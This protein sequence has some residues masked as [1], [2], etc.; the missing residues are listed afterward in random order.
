MKFYLSIICILF[1][2]RLDSQEPPAPIGKFPENWV[3]IEIGINKM[4]EEDLGPLRDARKNVL[5]EMEG[6]FTGD[7]LV[8][9]KDSSDQV[10]VKLIS[11]KGLSVITRVI[12]KPLPEKILSVFQKFETSAVSEFRSSGIKWNPQFRTQVAYRAHTAING[13]KYITYGKVADKHSPKA[14]EKA[15]SFLLKLKLSSVPKED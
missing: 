14:F 11:K 3:M 7:H 4:P 12:K 2:A 13:K 5:H 10:N 9:T 15:K 8:F 6:A 1:I